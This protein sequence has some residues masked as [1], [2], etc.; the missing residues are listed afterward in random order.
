MTYHNILLGLYVLQVTAGVCVMIA[1]V[2]LIRE[3]N[4]TIEPT[5][6]DERE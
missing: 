1:S 5:R 6:N 3:L 2:N 4:K